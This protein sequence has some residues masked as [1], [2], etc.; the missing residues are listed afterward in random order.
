MHPHVEAAL[1][2]LYRVIDA[3][4][5]VGLPE[6]NLGLLPGGQ[7]TQRLPRLVGCEA[8]LQLSSDAPPKWRCE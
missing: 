5:S 8:A 1:G 7:G 3:A 6:V 2:C 4:A